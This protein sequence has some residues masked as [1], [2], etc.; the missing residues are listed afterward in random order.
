MRKITVYW[1]FTSFIIIVGAQLHKISAE[2]LTEGFQSDNSAAVVSYGIILKILPFIIYALVA[3]FIIL[4]YRADIDFRS[5]N[6]K[7]L[8]L[9]AIFSGA[10]SIIPICL[11]FGVIPP[12]ESIAVFSLGFASYTYLFLFLFAAFSSIAMRKDSK[13]SVY[14]KTADR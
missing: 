1:L 11:N 7:I 13:K 9:P 6:K 8:L 10:M 14:D 2:K 12:S 5:S 4:V 3:L